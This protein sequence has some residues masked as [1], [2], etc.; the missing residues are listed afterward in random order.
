MT[1]LWLI[2]VPSTCGAKSTYAKWN[3]SKCDTVFIICQTVSSRSSYVATH[4]CIRRSAACDA[5]W[6]DSCETT[7]ANCA[8]LSLWRIV[9]SSVRIY[10]THVHGKLAGHVL[11]QH[12]SARARVRNICCKQTQPLQTNY[13]VAASLMNPIA[14]VALIVSFVLRKRRANTKKF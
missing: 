10:N 5:S 3:I 8:A 1:C 7:M 6:S 11:A 13:T 9:F 4:I 12:H 14:C 2:E